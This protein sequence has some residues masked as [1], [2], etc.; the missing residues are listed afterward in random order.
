MHWQVK[1]ARHPINPNRAW[2]AIPG[3]ALN[4]AHRFPTWRQAHAYAMKRA[5]G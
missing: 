4:R 5:Y 2:L 1:K 3:K